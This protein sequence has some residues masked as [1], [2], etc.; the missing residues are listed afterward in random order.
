MERYGPEEGRVTD[1]GSLRRF[2]RPIDQKIQWLAVKFPAQ[3]NRELIAWIRNPQDETANLIDK[4][5]TLPDANFHTHESCLYVYR[6]I[7]TG[8]S[9]LRAI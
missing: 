3:S 6:S 8:E 2:R 7:Q 9:P 1:L 4:I 5:D